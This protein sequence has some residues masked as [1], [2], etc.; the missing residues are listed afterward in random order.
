M[1]APFAA[2]EGKPYAGVFFT[3]QCGHAQYCTPFARADVDAALQEAAEYW[4]L[5]AGVQV[6]TESDTHGVIKCYHVFNRTSH[7]TGLN[8]LKNTA[9][10]L[11]ISPNIR[12]PAGC[13]ARQDV[14][15][16]L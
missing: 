16:M 14:H 3:A 12:P 6:Q 15:H 2:M 5:I 10:H 8:Q 4:Q 7:S 13:W 1:P 11:S 9:F